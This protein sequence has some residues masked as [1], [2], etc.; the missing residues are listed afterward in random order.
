M[1][2]SKIIKELANGSID[3]QT[4]LKRTKVLLQDLGNEEI[5]QWVNYEVEG[6]PSDVDVPE[7]RRI[8]GQLYGSYFKG[9]IATHVQYRNI[10]LPLGKMPEKIKQ[11]L[12]TC[13]ITQGID[14]LKHMVEESIN[15]GNPICKVVPADFYPNIAHYNDDLGMIISSARV[16]LSKPDLLNIAPKVENR[17]LDILSYLEKQFGNL[18]DLDID[19]ESKNEGE[20]KEIVDHIHVLIY[21]DHRVTIGDGNEITDSTIA[22]IVSQ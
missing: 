17:L 2:K 14:A 8:S 4:A 18:D 7:Y 12:L 10:P 6:Y 21:N 5:L 19:I 9:S 1:A 13:D 16:E 20:L 3:T 15:S 11:V 22:S